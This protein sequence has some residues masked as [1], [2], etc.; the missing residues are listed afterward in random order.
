MSTKA[1][2]LLA[3]FD[4]APAAPIG[5]LIGIFTQQNQS[6]AAIDAAYKKY[7]PLS[8]EQMSSYAKMLASWY[9]RSPAGSAGLTTS[10]ALSGIDPDDPEAAPG[11]GPALALD[12][13]VQ[14]EVDLRKSDAKP[15][16]VAG[17]A[18][19]LANEPDQSF[20]EQNWL[21]PVKAFTRNSIM[22]LGMP[23][24]AV[25]NTIR[26]T[27][28][29]L[30]K[31][32]LGG[33]AA[34]ALALNPLASVIGEAATGGEFQNPWE[35]TNMGAL[36]TQK[37]GLQESAAG[38]ADVGEGWMWSSPEFEKNIEK[39]HKSQAQVTFENGD[40]AQAWTIGRGITSLFTESADEAAY[41]IGSGFI[42][43]AAAI[44]L[45]PLTYVPG[46]AIG[47]GAR[48]I[49]GTGTGAVTEMGKA[50]N[51]AREEQIGVRL[52]ESGLD[53]EQI[54]DYL[55]MRSEGSLPDEAVLA[56]HAQDAERAGD[57]AAAARARAVEKEARFDRWMDDN[58]ELMS[59]W[60][61]TRD[62]AVRGV[63]DDWGDLY[64]WDGHTPRQYEDA[65]RQAEAWDQEYSDLVATE[66]AA[67]AGLPQGR[68]YLTKP[69]REIAES[70]VRRF[71]AEDVQSLLDTLVGVGGHLDGSHPSEWAG[72]LTYADDSGDFLPGV[73]AGGDVALRRGTPEPAP[74]TLDEA[75]APKPFDVGDKVRIGK[76]KV[77]WTVG[78]TY[79]DGTVT[80]DAPNGAIRRIEPGGLDRLVNLSREPGAPA[81]QAWRAAD[82]D[83]LVDNPDGLYSLLLPMLEKGTRDPEDAKAAWAH[84]LGGGE[85]TWGHVFSLAAQ[86]GQTTALGAALRLLDG[87]PQAIDNI[88]A[89]LGSDMENLRWIA[90]GASVE[91]APLDENVPAWLAR[92]A[93]NSVSERRK[94]LLRRK[95]EL[96]AELKSQEAAHQTQRLWL[97]AKNRKVAE[98]TQKAAV[99]EQKMREVLEAQARAQTAE[100]AAQAI[101]GLAPVSDEIA[102]A[103]RVEAGLHVDPVTLRKS[104]RDPQ[105]FVDFFTKSL[106]GRKVMERLVEIKDPA[107][108]ALAMGNK[109]DGPDAGKVYRAIAEADNVED[110]TALL[111][112]RA[113]ME[114][115]GRQ[116]VWRGA[117][118]LNGSAS[119]GAVPKGPKMLARR[120]GAFLP[121]GRMLDLSDPTQLATE[122][123]NIGRAVGM[124]DDQIAEMI[125]PFYTDDRVG[126][127]RT[128]AIEAMRHVQR[129]QLAKVTDQSWEDVKKAAYEDPDSAIARTWA[130]IDEATTLFGDSMG[131]VSRY[132][133]GVI[134]DDAAPGVF[135]V[136]GQEV[137]IPDAYTDAE[138]ADGMVFL[139]DFQVMNR[140]MNHMYRAINGKSDIAEKFINWVDYI[141]TDLW[142]TS[143]LAFRPAY[144]FR[145]Q[146]EM[147]V[148]GFLNGSVGAW[149]H[150]LTHLS[151]AMNSKERSE[152][153]ASIA[154]A[155]EKVNGSYNVDPGGK[156]L[157]V[158]DSQDDLMRVAQYQDEF[159][160]MM[161]VRRSTSDPRY[162]RLGKRVG[163][164]MVKPGLGKESRQFNNAWAQNLLVHRTGKVEQAVLGTPANPELYAALAA[165][166]GDD[167]AESGL[168][169]FHD[170][171]YQQ[172]VSDWF[173]ESAEGALLR[174]ELAKNSAEVGKVVDDPDARMDYLFGE[175]GDSV[176]STQRV[177]TNNFD[178]AL[179]RFYRTGVITSSKKKVG[180]FSVA[181]SADPLAREREVATRLRELSLAD[182]VKAKMGEQGLP[183]RLA[184]YDMTDPNAPGATLDRAVD[185]FFGIAAGIERAGA[186]GPEYKAEVWTHIRDIAP[187]LDADALAL[188]RQHSSQIGAKSLF[189][190]QLKRALDK[191]DGSGFITADEMSHLANQKAARHVRDLYYHS[192]DR[193]QFWSAT[194]LAFPFGQA[195]ANSVTKWLTLSA[196]N[197]Q[198]V[199]KAA[200]LL[201][202]LQSEESDAIYD[203]PG[204]G[205]DMEP[206]DPNEPDGGF[207]FADPSG[208]DTQQMFRYPV[209]LT[210][211]AGLVPFM[212]DIGDDALML[213]NAKSLD[214]AFG[215][216]APLPGVG[217]L[218][219][220]ASGVTGLETKSGPLSDVLRKW[221]APMGTPDVEEGL[222][223][224][225]S[226]NWVDGMVGAVFGNDRTYRQQFAGAAAWVLS[227]EGRGLNELSSPQAQE[228]VMAEVDMVARL[229]G[230]FRAIGQATLPASP[231]IAWRGERA[232]GSEEFLARMGKD[233]REMEA[234]V[235]REEAIG[236]FMDK[237]SP[238]ALVSTMALTRGDR[239]LTSPAWD[240]YRENTSDAEKIGMDALSTIFFG[241]VS[242]D[243]MAWQK[244]RGDRQALTL[245][246]MR[247]GWI[248]MAYA[249][250]KASINQRR[251][252]EG[253]TTEQYEA[254]LEAL[255]DE[256]GGKPPSS[257]DAGGLERQERS[258]RRALSMPSVQALPQY[259]GM[260]MALDSYDL[261]LAAY[262]E[263]TGEADA[264]LT[265]KKAWAYRESL[266]ADL[267]EIEE[268]SR[269]KDSPLAGSASGVIAMIESLIKPSKG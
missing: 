134:A 59:E 180:N 75:A 146:L 254:E 195:W 71:G 65:R 155:I 130:V 13:M 137:R 229:T 16:S 31:G 242:P 164:V 232:D 127:N 69:G 230:L 218:V 105:R 7:E 2:R 226:P 60:E 163:Q 262:R 203:L 181:M 87:S 251:A 89:A 178:P 49:R 250:A 83:E 95:R 201:N 139:P 177:L 200:K 154:K 61:R 187:M 41:R 241:D 252:Q 132:L 25:A 67:K 39:V 259:A 53:E 261:H 125:R 222:L 70:W 128:A 32:D 34:Q 244:K 212:P 268:A 190:V 22:A 37:A 119:L 179:I 80:L 171:E 42:D 116:N 257:I 11:L 92:R 168:W 194:R 193:R 245:P 30:Q 167:V 258:V 197:P 159:L 23:F 104:I 17:N 185:W 147:G 152:V 113:G 141:Y 160:S 142:R 57:Q 9:R 186:F 29:Q 136:R 109:L 170:P 85:A 73:G 216:T 96:A 8:D 133:N 224:Y 3:S 198:Q 144:I 38:N 165:R 233:Y 246:Q 72:W 107:K 99:A 266:M 210:K 215:Q 227:Q 64:P 103:M 188:A 183:Y 93:A 148:R 220:M 44:F 143:M 97:Q 236:L 206:D 50:I 6:Q 264:T 221:I 10:L 102:Q 40:P 263:A 150:P 111:M 63:E 84:L 199:Y 239:P 204:M 249:A 205:G 157:A 269:S 129:H 214:F 46:G 118:L 36:I 135:M 48:A 225:L 172:I 124:D 106:K 68:V 123:T 182:D 219:Q 140:R 112:T 82:A 223:E 26:G 173:Q 211:L 151:M 237:Y 191:A 265:G 126:T 18:A 138:H 56:K 28:G 120:M 202:A 52:A 240:F 131:I 74:G 253:M 169:P 238:E 76:G 174:E 209:A 161:L 1:E 121:S 98:A 62:S 248:G 55:R 114:F 94:D 24:E 45:D 217:P 90:P 78:N 51:L 196:Q 231:T 15:G 166:F 47:K 81:G 110:V 189:G 192:T 77:E 234:L 5:T 115:D 228:Q 247:D 88:G 145:N 149:N 91:V 58:A 66:E 162:G 260:K 184:K 12:A 122:Y 19:L 4:A 79:P 175:R 153:V 21:D 156:I 267:A 20:W 86:H 33:A 176:L 100:E 207:L 14:A 255:D 101:R 54:A 213:G 243:A 27:V 208:Y 158:P 256:F 43:A 108:V 235:G 35:S 117:P